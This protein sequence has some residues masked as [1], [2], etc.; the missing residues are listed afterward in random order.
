M[1]H[2][3]GGTRLGL[4][5]LGRDSRARGLDALDARQVAIEPAPA[6]RQRLRMRRHAA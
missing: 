4:R 2:D 3:R 5:E 6:L 1:I